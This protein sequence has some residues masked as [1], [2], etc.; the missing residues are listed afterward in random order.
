MGTHAASISTPEQSSCQDW[1]R[2]SDS[3]DEDEDAFMFHGSAF[4]EDEDDE[5]E[6]DAAESEE[7]AAQQPSGAE[8]AEPTR[9]GFS[10]ISGGIMEKELKAG[11]GPVLALKQSAVHKI[12]EREAERKERAI[13]AK[14]RHA[15]NTQNSILPYD[16]STLN[17]EKTLIKIATK[18]V[19]KL[20]TAVVAQNAD[21]ASSLPHNKPRKSIP[22]VDDS[23]DE[24]P[25][26]LSKGKMQAMVQQ[27]RA[28]LQSNND[29]DAKKQKTGAAWMSDNFATADPKA[30]D[31]ESDSD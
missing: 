16:E 15:L 26:Q 29:N 24:Q 13:V 31:Q 1:D 20:F 8:Q 2:M 19:V 22:G 9:S 14:T 21:A 11:A 6:D 3:D 25:A 30:W 23:D 5:E 27:K 4:D 12:Q 18:G 17:L 10:K 7:E 28:E